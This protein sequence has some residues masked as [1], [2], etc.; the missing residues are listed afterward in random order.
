MCQ[1]HNAD[2]KQC[3]ITYLRP[4]SD[5]L[6]SSLYCRLF[7]QWGFEQSGCQQ[8]CL[9]RRTHGGRQDYHATYLALSF[10]SAVNHLVRGMGA[11]ASIRGVG[12]Q[13]LVRG[14]LW[15]CQN[16]DAKE[17]TK[18]YLRPTCRLF[19]R[20]GFEGNGCQ[21]SSLGRRHTHGMPRSPC[22]MQHTWFFL[23]FWLSNSLALALACETERWIGSK[24]KMRTHEP[25][26]KDL[27]GM[28]LCVI[29]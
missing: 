27:Q 22:I 8:L 10:P 19:L 18:T 29:R 26:E 11:V 24:R 14:T 4:P 23:I 1:S 21:Q 2:A 25:A 7:L 13:C 6:R 20:W 3:K 28:C 17:C 16:S 15:R 12:R 5:G 9:G